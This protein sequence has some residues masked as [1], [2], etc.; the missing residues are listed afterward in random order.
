MSEVKA[1]VICQSP[2]LVLRELSA[3]DSSDVAFMRQL[4]NDP[5]W[6]RFIGDRKVHDEESGRAYVRKVTASYVDNGFGFWAVCTRASDGTPTEPPIGIC[7]LT[8]RGTLPA[9]DLGFA[10]LPAGRGQGQAREA[11]KACVEH[12]RAELGLGELLAITDPANLRS[13]RLLES[14]GFTLRRKEQL[15]PDDIELCVFGLTP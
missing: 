2:R 6:L 12:A 11:A 7:G 4:V 13:I 9:P 3:D 14:L 10:F 8:R 1:K 5:G 15:D